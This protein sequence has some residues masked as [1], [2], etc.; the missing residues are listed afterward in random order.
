MMVMS[1]TLSIGRDVHQM[2]PVP[3]LGKPA[4]QSFSKHTAV[5]EKSFERDCPGDRSIVEKHGDLPARRQSQQIRLRG[6]NSLL[7]YILPSARAD[8]SYTARLPW[9]ENRKTDAIISEQV[10]RLQIDRSFR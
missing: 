5:I 2:R 9:R 4:H 7:A 1:V 8:F 3:L 10:E 6:I